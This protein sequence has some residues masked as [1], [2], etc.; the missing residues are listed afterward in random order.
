LILASLFLIAIALYTK[1]NFSI[2]L[3]DHGG[4]FI[5]ALMAVPIYGF[6][7]GLKYTTASNT[8]DNRTA[9]IFIVLLGLVFKERLNL[10][11]IAGFNAFLAASAYQ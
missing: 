1:R 8:V 5:L 3:K 9:P 6:S 4:I 2:T 11:K 7:N 10:I